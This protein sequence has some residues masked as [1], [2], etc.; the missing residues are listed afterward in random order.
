MSIGGGA[1]AR[2][3]L[4]WVKCLPIAES[5]TQFLLDFANPG[6]GLLSPAHQRAIANL[7]LAAA[8]Y[9]QYQNDP[10]VEQTNLA[11]DMLFKAIVTVAEISGYSEAQAEEIYSNPTILKK[12][13]HQINQLSGVIG[14]D[15]PV[16]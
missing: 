5:M 4:D 7:Q 3:G 13:A 10:N 11:T 16:S 6:N 8:E 12:L 1:V 14:F 9:A 2:D 15:R